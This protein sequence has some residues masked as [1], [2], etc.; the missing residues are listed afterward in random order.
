MSECTYE[1]F[2]VIMQPAKEEEMLNLKEKLSIL[3]RSTI[4][5]L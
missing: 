4:V 2:T 3:C 1:G 5:G